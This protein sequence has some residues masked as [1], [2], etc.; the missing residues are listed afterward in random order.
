RQRSGLTAWRSWST[1]AW[2]RSPPTT[3]S[4]S[5]ATAMRDCG[6][7]GK[8]AWPHRR[9]PKSK[10]H[11]LVQRAAPIASELTGRSGRV[12][13]RKEQI[14]LIAVAVELDARPRLVRASCFHQRRE[15][16]A[17]PFVHLRGLAPKP[18]PQVAAAGERARLQTER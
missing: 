3:S 12:G 1:V 11:T 15:R 10:D 8:R 14:N 9:S 4:S 13:D 5:R 18:R 6:H 16:G 17:H 7:R 2:S